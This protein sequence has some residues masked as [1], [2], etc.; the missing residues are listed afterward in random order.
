MRVR[1]IKDQAGIKVGTISE[2][3][4][5]TGCYFDNT[6]YVHIEYCNKYP[7]FYQIINDHELILSELV[8]GKCYKN[9]RTGK[10]GKFENAVLGGAYLIGRFEY[11]CDRFD[12]FVEIAE[13]KPSPKE[14]GELE[15]LSA[16]LEKIGN[17]SPVD[18]D[19]YVQ[20]LYRVLKGTIEHL[21]AKERS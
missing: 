15:T 10:V 14:K 5:G 12:L 8:E 4:G 18:D 6:G 17:P 21:I 1:A 2:Y 11:E 13:G 16:I 20:V 9:L 19:V 7:E 3:L